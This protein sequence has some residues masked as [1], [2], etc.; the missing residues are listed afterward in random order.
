MSACV[1]LSLQSGNNS[2]NPC[3][4]CVSVREVGRDDLVLAAVRELL[5]PGDLH[6]LLPRL[7][8]VE[9]GEPGLA[10]RQGAQGG[11]GLG[12]LHEGALHAHR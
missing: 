3:P 5:V 7:H 4:T 9:T 6:H 2:L 8:P 1:F 11:D 12:G 10:L